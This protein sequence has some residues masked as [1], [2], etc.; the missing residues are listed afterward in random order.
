MARCLVDLALRCQE[1]AS[2]YGGLEIVN[3]YVDAAVSGSS[4][5]LR[6]GM[7]NLLQDSLSEKLDLVVSESLDRLSRNLHDISGL[8]KQLEFAGM[9]IVTLSEGEITT[10]HVGLKGT[11]SELFLKDRADKTRRG[12]RGKVESGKS[13]GRIAYGYQVVKQFNTNGEAIRGD[14][15]TDEAQAKIV[16]RIFRE[17]ANDNKSPK[18]ITA[19]LNAESIP[20][21]PGK[22]WGQSTMNGNRRSGTGILN[23]PLYI[24]EL[25]WNRQ[26]FLKDPSTGK[27]VSRYNPESEWIRQSVPD[28]RIVPQELW[29]AAKA[30]QSELDKRSGNLGARKRP[31]YLLSGLL[32]CGCCGGG[33]S[34]INSERYGC[35]SARNK[36]ASVCANKQTIK[37]DVLEGKVLSA[38][39]EHLMRDD[40]VQVFYEEYTSH[41]NDLR[42]A[43]NAALTNFRKE[44]DELAALMKQQDEEPRP[45]IHPTMS[46]RYRSK[47]DALMKA[48]GDG[49]AGEAREQVRALIDRI[50]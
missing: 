12:L 50:V 27:R 43:H 4:M 24:G 5:M 22:A 19:Q 1:V 44:A 6:T 42:T 41:M 17:Y 13:G 3:T 31:Q 28:L 49:G 35:S 15:E 39:Q 10:M 36:G 30:R 40:L 20:F 47:I 9:K 33:Y 46:R 25:I 21:P 26:K 8:H 2:K 48:L 32:V 37:R 14:R 11:M 45:L 38:L 29:D 16:R 18:A 7:Q 23:N 34:K